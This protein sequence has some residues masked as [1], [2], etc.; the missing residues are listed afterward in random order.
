[1]QQHKTLQRLWVIAISALI[2]IGLTAG[3][4]DNDFPQVHAN[5]EQFLDHVRSG[6]IEQAAEYVAPAQRERAL[7]ELSQVTAHMEQAAA[8]RNGFRSMEV[9]CEIEANLG[10]CRVATMYGN[11]EVIRDQIGVI[12]IDGHWWIAPFP[13]EQRQPIDVDDR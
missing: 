7:Q 9:G 10:L 13:A 3:C 12:R 5:A 6:E 4:A 1:M 8:D 11:G 2:A